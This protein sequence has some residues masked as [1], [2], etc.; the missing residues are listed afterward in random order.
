MVGDNKKTANRGALSCG[1]ACPGACE[2]ACVSDATSTS[3]PAGQRSAKA[4]P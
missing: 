1:H 3:V 4:M 2:P